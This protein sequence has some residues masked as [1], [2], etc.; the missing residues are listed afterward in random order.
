MC[1]ESTSLTLPLGQNNRSC[2]ERSSPL[3]N[4]YPTGEEFTSWKGS[5]AL[6]LEK[7][8]LRMGACESRGSCFDWSI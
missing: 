7:F 2:F 4:R 6:H 8:M 1:L 3:D 5:D